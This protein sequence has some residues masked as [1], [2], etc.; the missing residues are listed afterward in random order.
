MAGRIL[1]A[2]VDGGNDPVARLPIVDARAR[3]F[4]PEPFRY[5]GARMIREA[6]VRKDEVQDQGRR[7]NPLVRAVAQLPRWLGY[8]FGH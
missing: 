4:P 2:I 6:L 7:P 8:P 1:G 3:R 5:V